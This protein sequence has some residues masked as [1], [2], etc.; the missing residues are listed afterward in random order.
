MRVTD[1]NSGFT[2]LEVMIALALIGAVLVTILYTVNYQADLSYE[3]AIL[4]EM[5]LLARKKIVEMERNPEESKG[6]VPDTDFV[7][8]NTVNTIPDTNI[9]ELKTT[10]EGK[11]KSVTL[12]EVIVRR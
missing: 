6:T 12:R 3:N 5:Y 2:L 10:I 9:L 7:F 8:I 4:T 1:S 11:G